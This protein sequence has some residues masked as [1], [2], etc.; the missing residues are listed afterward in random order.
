MSDV[1]CA[2]VCECMSFAREVGVFFV[3]RC[4]HEPFLPYLCQ[5]KEKCMCSLCVL[6]MVSPF[7]V[8]KSPT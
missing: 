7:Y 3:L 8:Y 6:Y 1:V 4:L 2:V 5:I